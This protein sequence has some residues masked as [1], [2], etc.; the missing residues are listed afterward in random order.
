MAAAK[1][2][3]S[4]TQ[5]VLDNNSS[6]WRTCPLTHATQTLFDIRHADRNHYLTLT[7]GG[8][9]IFCVLYPPNISMCVGMR[10]GEGCGK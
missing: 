4:V 8:L 9:A 1:S 7:L 3:E 6:S 10:E 5:A 2:D